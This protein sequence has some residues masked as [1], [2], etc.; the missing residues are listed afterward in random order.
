MKDRYTQTNWQRNTKTT[1]SRARFVWLPI[2]LNAFALLCLNIPAAEAQNM[3]WTDERGIHRAGIDGGNPETILPVT[4]FDP[5]GVAIDTVR[6]KI[7]WTDDDLQEI[8]RANLDGTN[9]ETI[10][11]EL[12]S[13]LGIAIDPVGEKIY[14]TDWAKSKIQRANLDGTNVETIVGGLEQPFGIAVDPLGG[15]IYWVDNRAKQIQRSNL[16][17]TDIETIVVELEDPFGIDIDVEGG[18][19][20]WTERSFPSTKIQ[21]T[22]LDGTNVED[23][24]I[25][26]P[27]FINGIAVDTSGGKVYWTDN[28][29]DRI[30]RANLD[31]TNVEDFVT[32]GLS[33]L[34][35]IAVDPRGG[36]VYW[37]DS[38]THKIQRANV[39]GTALEDVVT[40]AV[41]NPAGIAVDKVEEKRYWTDSETAKIQRANLDGTALEDL[42]TVE[43]RSEL[44]GIAVHAVGEKIYWT[45]SRAET[46]Q[47][48]NLDGT[49]VEDLFAGLSEPQGIAV[50][51][52]REKIY[53]ADDGFNEKIQRSDLDGA[54]IEELITTELEEPRGIAVDAVSGKIY[55][56]D[57]QNGNVQCAN[58]D[59]T[60]VEVLV[61][62]LVDPYGI[63]VDLRRWKVYW[64]DYESGVIQRANLDG[65]AVEDVVTDLVRPRYITFDMM[66][67]PASTPAEMEATVSPNPL[68]AVSGATATVTLT[69]T[70][71]LGNPVIGEAV[72]LVASA[73]GISE[74]ATEA[75]NGVY[76]AIYTPG[77]S[78]GDVDIQART[79]N[80]IVEF[81]ILRLA[82]MAQVSRT[83]IN[84]GIV[85]VGFSG[86]ETFTA[87]NAGDS[88][89]SVSDITSSNPQ[90]DVSP[91]GFDLSA[92]ASQSV[93][94]TFQPTV[95]GWERSFLT[96]TYDAVGSP[97]IIETNGIGTVT[98]PVGSLAN[99]KITFRS[100]RDN[101]EGNR[102]GRFR[103]GEIYIMNADG[104]NQ[105]RL[106]F[107]DTSNSFPSWSPD[108]M[109]VAYE[110]YLDRNLEIY[111]MHTDGGSNPVNLTQHPADDSAP[112]WSPD[113][114][115]LTFVSDR[116]GNEDI[117]LMNAD[118]TGQRRLTRNTAEDI[119]P[120][121][122]PDGAKIAF[123]SERDGNFE[124]YVIN[125]DGSPNPINLTNHL[126]N[127]D[128]PVWS[129]DG[130]KVAFTTSRDGN[131]EIYVMN[132]DGTRPTRLTFNAAIDWAPSWSPDGTKL[133]F[134]SRRHGVAE[135]Y[136][137][138][139][140]GTRPKRLTENMMADTNPDWSPFVAEAPAAAADISISIRPDRLIAGSGATA[141][142][143]ITVID[144]LGNF[145][146]GETTSLT[147][148]N[149]SI[150]ET[151]TEQ[152]NGLYT[153]TYTS[154]TGL[155]KA[156]T[157][158]I[159]ATASNDVSETATL[160]L[161]AKEASITKLTGILQPSAPRLLESVNLLGV[162]VVIDDEPPPV[163]ASVIQI[164]FT[165]P[166]GTTFLFEVETDNQGNYSLPN[167]FILSEVGEWNLTTRFEGTG[168]VKASE[169]SFAF[170][171][172]KG[173]PAITFDTGSI[174]TL[175]REIEIIGRLVADIDRGADLSLKIRR[176]DA[177]VATLE[178]ITTESVGVFRHPL[179]LDA[180]GDWEVRVTW[181]G[182]DNYEPVTEPLIIHVTEEVGKAILVLGGGNRKDNPAWETFNGLAGYVRDVFK[183][184]NFN[185]DTD[186]QFLSPAPTQ[187]EGADTETTVS[188]LELAITNWAKSRVNPQVPLFLYLLSHN[189]ED[190]FLLEKRGEQEI[191]LSPSQLDFWLDQLPEGT[192][193]TI[194]IEACHSGNF[195][196][197]ADGQPTALI[198]ANRLII[199][200]ARGDK[201]A[202]ILPNRSSFSKTFFDQVKV[203][204]TIEEAFREADRFMQ[205]APVHRDQFPQLDANGNG[206][207]NEAQDFVAVAER[208]LP[209]DITTL[210]ALPEF[211]ALDPLELGA[212][213]DPLELGALEDALELGSLEDPLELGSLERFVISTELLG[214]NISNVS[215]TVIPPDFDP[216]QPLDD[217]NALSFD[218]FDLVEIDTGK[219][220]ALYSNFTLPGDYTIIVNAENS[221]GSAVPVQTTI[222][223]PGEEAPATPWDVNSDGVV[224]I[225]DLA[226][227]GS[228][229]GESGP[230]LSGDVNGDGAVN[231]QDLV[232]VGSHFGASTTATAPSLVSIRSS[233]FGRFSS[234]RL[235]SLLQVSPRSDDFSRFPDAQLKSLRQ[236]LTELE[237]V[238]NPSQGSIIARDFLRAWLSQL[239]PIVT[240]TKLLPNYPNP[241]NPET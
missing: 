122:S 9:V 85:N 70:D 192:P 152:G 189:L 1:F 109:Q 111:L 218:E 17:G 82:S 25:S 212:L 113:G 119:Q 89:L 145:L 19:I 229:F 47:R 178:G 61:T 53:W 28:S 75:G 159:R 211:I 179:K 14:W 156:D 149:G 44:N 148:S 54:N 158:V 234:E 164:I 102:H 35:G 208:H 197:T 216:A 138:N 143:I 236:A 84:M 68:I 144:E 100:E 48:S 186:I 133:A 13:S 59:G 213:E 67:P 157:V 49:D 199:V 18:K 214:V 101:S 107:N 162:L 220:A 225:L 137:M 187:T 30:Q 177:S 36:K 190:Q 147:A 193:V 93:T 104:K 222:T 185:D 198:D 204:K 175:G 131:G 194:I 38:G 206:I 78:L 87:T 172:A 39:D 120:S 239:K 195:I 226:I 96:M 58:L 235:K 26:L 27:R 128:L 72:T 191:F 95:V 22:N 171:V 200:S 8:R 66:P 74:T 135:I 64:T 69:V 77:A 207:P 55:W 130:T 203:N 31:G 106:T 83:V 153:A 141:K 182:D 3:Y 233:D 163:E 196:Q 224:N 165:A 121:W 117:Y 91:M 174:G 60:D 16:D 21:R 71:A 86:I 6:G 124:I 201:Q 146:A 88:L 46:I 170:T 65:T 125:A 56:T 151:A 40:T 237:A 140:N 7:Y 136:V 43:S 90:F 202:K 76:T 15:K 129:P 2:L 73:G 103:I 173:I 62:G 92:G 105:A 52:N 219:Y 161:V 20:Y 123:A 32:T 181:V 50:D 34:L 33:G 155:G 10:V 114:T 167:D 98:P 209:A 232:L 134:S 42:V 168:T 183:K 112:S 108:G 127:D 150:P 80:G 221:D 223:I 240:E 217:W 205:S 110:S 29:L 51:V 227:V 241:F 81:A 99:S 4:L 180:A 118:G 116:S 231:V 188:T 160:T 12:A 97:A 184:R 5:D 228:Q 11:T 126:D 176:P 24:V 45:D 169:R 210:F 154:P 57:G 230:D 166:S 79:S 238:P 132:A 37:T 115:R 142:V 139:A 41:A 23:L 63:A 94:V 215:A